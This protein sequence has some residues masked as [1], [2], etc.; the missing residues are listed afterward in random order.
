MNRRLGLPAVIAAGLMLLAGGCS[1]IECP[2]N[3]TVYT[4]YKLAGNVTTLTG[5]LTVAIKRTSGTDSVLI[6]QDTKVDSLMIP[7][8]YVQAEDELHFQLTTTDGTTV[9]D[10]VKVKKTDH[11]HFESVDCNPAYFH[12][13]TGVSYTTHAI[14]SVVINQPNVTYDATTPHFRLYFRT[15]N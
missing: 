14:D 9:N 5:T 1:S 6:N 15:G 10:T 3:N 11:P 13:I 12:T 7:M 8:S 4:K 2:L